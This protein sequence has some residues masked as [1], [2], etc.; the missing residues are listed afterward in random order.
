MSSNDVVVRMARGALPPDGWVDPASGALDVIAVC[1]KLT[2]HGMPSRQV[3]PRRGPVICRTCRRDHHPRL[4]IGVAEHQP[5]T[6]FVDLTH[7]GVDVGGDLG[8]QRRREHRPCTVTR[9]LVE[10][11][12]A[13]LAVL[14]GRIRVVDYLEHGR[15]FPNQRANAGS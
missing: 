6:R 14:I 10:Q 12:P 5:V 8:L 13:R 11:R 7:V 4:V 3:S 9:D 15:T 2:K 1:K